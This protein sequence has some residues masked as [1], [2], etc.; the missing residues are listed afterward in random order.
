MVRPAVIS[1]LILTA[2]SFVRIISVLFAFV[3]SDNYIGEASRKLGIWV[4]QAKQAKLTCS[5]N[6]FVIITWI[7]LML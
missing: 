6:F 1:D 2:G 7:F 3:P 4:V 5:S